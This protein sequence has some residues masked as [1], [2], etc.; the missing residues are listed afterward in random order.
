MRYIEYFESWQ[1]QGEKNTAFEREVL[2]LIKDFN[3]DIEEFIKKGNSIEDLLD[4]KKLHTFKNNASF[5][6]SHIKNGKK[7]YFCDFN[8]GDI[9]FCYLI[10]NNKC[11]GVCVYKLDVRDDM[12]YYVISDIGVVSTKRRKGYG[13]DIIEHIEELHPG[14]NYFDKTMTTIKGDRFFHKV[15]GSPLAYKENEY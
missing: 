4:T 3:W 13:R 5:N 2:G 7:I 8:L 10:E 12:K 6:F 9:F 11:I 14:Y 1:D 15:K